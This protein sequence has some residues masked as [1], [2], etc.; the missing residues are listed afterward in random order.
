[1][2]NERS[3]LAN[4]KFDLAD[5]PTSASARRML[6][7]VS[8]GF[9]DSS[10]V[11]KW[12]YQVMGLEYDSA[13]EILE[14]LPE[15]MFPETA[16]WGL[17]YHEIKWGLPV[18]ENLTYEERRKAIFQKRDYRAP[19]TPYRMET[20]LADV[21]GFEVHVC[22][23]HDDGGY[24]FVFAHP[25]VFKAVFIG[26]GTLDSKEAHRQLDKL[27]QSHTVYTVNDRTEILLDSRTLE[28]ILVSNINI[29]ARIP[30]WRTALLDGE[31]LLDGSHLLDAM[32]DYDLRIGLLY[33]QGEFVTTQA[34]D[35]HSVIVCWRQELSESFGGAN[36]RIGFIVPFWGVLTLNGDVF[37]D[38]SE[39]LDK[40]RTE[41]GAAVAVHL[42]E[43]LAT[44]SAGNATCITRRNLAYLD[45]SLKLDGT[46]K[47]NSLYEKEVI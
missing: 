29:K 40:C 21:T 13:L 15:Q 16:T 31:W 32:R 46:R 12:L 9:Y 37:L 22:D 18:R 33:R 47:L 30:F 26:E 25:N 10:Y 1:M 42:K 44:E 19:M 27:K 8:G 38:G 5:F 39:L 24:G 34:A 36:A 4:E 45:G 41:M 17:M 3:D 28:T 6:S 20:L 14:T 43:D 2:A 35:V 11:G 23:I 7:Y